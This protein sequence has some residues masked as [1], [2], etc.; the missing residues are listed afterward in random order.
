MCFCA[1]RK[2]GKGI[3]LGIWAYVVAGWYKQSTKPRPVGVPDCMCAW[4]GKICIKK[5][6]K[7]IIIVK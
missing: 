3:G 1:L 4:K 6:Y 2:V 7:V 5:K